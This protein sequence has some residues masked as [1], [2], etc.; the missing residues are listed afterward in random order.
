[1]NAT[2]GFI[3]ESS[4]RIAAAPGRRRPAPLPAIRRR[5]AARRPLTA[6]QLLHAVRHCHST[7]ELAKRSDQELRAALNHIRETR[8]PAD[9]ESGLVEIFAITD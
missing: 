2:A 9:P 7:R 5:F 8:N 6:R 3:P 4:D 1:M